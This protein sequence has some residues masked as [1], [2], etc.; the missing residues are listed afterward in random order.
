MQQLRVVVDTDIL[1][2]FGLTAYERKA[3]VSLVREG[4]STTYVLSK[5]SGV[6]Y[7]KIY[8]VLSTLER[9]GFVKKYDGTPQRFMA[10]EP[11]VAISAEIRKREREFVSLK[12]SSKSIIAALGALSAQKPTEP[13]EKIRIIE[14]YNNYLNL[15]VELHK[16]AK[17][18]WLSISEL[19]LY[20]PHID[21]YTD[22]VHRGVNVRMLTSQEEATKEKIKIWR[23]TKVD[24]RRASFIPTK[25]SVIDEREVTIRIASDE[26]YITLWIQ[27]PS[28][29]KSLKNYF[30]VL[31]ENAAIIKS[32]SD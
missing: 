27:N 22:N 32:P 4:I 6:P 11:N 8:P 21:A 28:L 18:E 20:K 14:G 13:L 1:E 15:S 16:K 12:D 29:A 23:K 30:N 17:Q 26:R 31:W 5:N 2:Q 25:F 3:Y 9:K 24:I 7:G 10:V 19:S